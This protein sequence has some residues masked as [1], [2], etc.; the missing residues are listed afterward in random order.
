[1]VEESGRR[2]VPTKLA[3]RRIGVSPASMEKWRSTGEVAIPFSKIGR[4]VVYDIGDLDAYVE[5]RKRVNTSE[6]VV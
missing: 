5:A 2:F 3:A 4:R 6:A 1:M